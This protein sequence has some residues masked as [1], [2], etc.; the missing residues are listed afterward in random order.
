MGDD[1][2]PGRSLKTLETAIEISDYIQD[3]SG[4]NVNDISEEFDLAP[5]TVHGYVTTLKNKGYINQTSEGLDIGL[6]FLAKGGYARTRSSEYKFIIE[7]IDNLSGETGERTQFI[8]E[9]QG[10]GY[11]I[12]TSIDEHAVQVDAQIGKKI[13]LHASSAGKAI[14]ASLPKERVNAIIERW[15]MP[16]H[17][18]N[19]ITD[20]QT[21]HQELDMIRARGYATNDEESIDGLRAVGVPI[22]TND[23]RTPIGAISVSAPVQRLKDDWPNVEVADYIQSVAN[24]IELEMKYR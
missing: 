19:T 22:Q 8:V 20:R 5:S 14:L 15:G 7:R 24:E 1:T 16:E 18:E 11:Y 10:R 13:Y 3:S 21:L 9:E 2:T 17:T 12:H 23:N 6:E 4:V